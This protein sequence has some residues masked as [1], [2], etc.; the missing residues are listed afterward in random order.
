MKRQKDLGL[1][2]EVGIHND[3]LYGYVLQCRILNTCGIEPKTLQ[4]NRQ[5]TADFKDFD[6]FRKGRVEQRASLRSR[7]TGRRHSRAAEEEHVPDRDLHQAKTRLSPGHERPGREDSLATVSE[8]SFVPQADR[9]FFTFREL[10]KR[11]TNE[12]CIKIIQQGERVSAEFADCFTA[13]VTGDTIEEIEDVRLSLFSVYDPFFQ[14]VLH[15]IKLHGGSEPWL[16]SGEAI[17]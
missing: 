16:P 5:F 12:T 3:N 13:S 2:F 10:N 9:F 11:L 14:A 4:L 8:R 17:P 15:V 7:R 1:F 6:Q